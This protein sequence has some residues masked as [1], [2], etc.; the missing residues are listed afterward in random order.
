[1][2]SWKR[3]GYPN[4]ESYNAYMRQYSKS[5]PEVR[6]SLKG[7][8]SRFRFKAKQREIN[9]DLT[10]EQWVGLAKDADC[11]YCHEKIQS[12]GI[13]L[14]RKDSGLGYV[15]GNVVPCCG[16][17]NKIRNE[18]LISYDEMVYIMPLLLAFR[19]ER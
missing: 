9:V 1:M 7:R 19:R 3:S 12:H 6:H 4:R 15:M 17:C 11:H 10:F 2:E 18:D 16:S 5:H 14:D 8:Y 13:S